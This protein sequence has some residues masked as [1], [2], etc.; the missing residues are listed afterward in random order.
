LHPVSTV[1]TIRCRAEGQKTKSR[2]R[3][4]REGK[5]AVD[6]ETE[7]FAALMYFALGLSHIVQLRA[8]AELFL[9]LKSQGKAGAFVDGFLNLLLG[10]TQR[11]FQLTG[12]GST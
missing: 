6:R 1:N 4:R 9:L 8:W 2:V 11:R 10:A 7:I 5:A 3:A 12:A